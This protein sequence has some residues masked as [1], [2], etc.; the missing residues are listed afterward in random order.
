M[1]VSLVFESLLGGK[2]LR[3]FVFDFLAGGGA[4]GG[5]DIGCP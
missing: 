5:C 3:E 4:M 1:E 2:K